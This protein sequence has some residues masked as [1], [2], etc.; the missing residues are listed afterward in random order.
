MRENL[1]YGLMRGKRAKPLRPTLQRRIIF[2]KRLSVFFVI[3]HSHVN[4]KKAE[5]ELLALFTEISIVN[6]YDL[7]FNLT[8]ETQYF[9]VIHK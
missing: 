1:T 6:R 3:V 2:E 5:H 7:F 4:E 8:Q 9:T